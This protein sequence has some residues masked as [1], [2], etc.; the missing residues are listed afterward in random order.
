[1]RFSKDIGSRLPLVQKLYDQKAATPCVAHGGRV[2]SVDRARLWRACVTARYVKGI[3]ALQMATTPFM[4]GLSKKLW[5][6]DFFKAR[7]GVRDVHSLGGGG[8]VFVPAFAE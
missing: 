4:E 8:F 7:A 6:G 3:Q 2:A 5:G 1:M